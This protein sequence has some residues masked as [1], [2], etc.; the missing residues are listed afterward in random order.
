MQE[1]AYI[2]DNKYDFHSRFVKR[3]P[4]VVINFVELQSKCK[5]FSAFPITYDFLINHF[6]PY[7]SSEK[8]INEKR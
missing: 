6:R 2:Y 4:Y 5:N 1:H 7:H 8:S 3:E